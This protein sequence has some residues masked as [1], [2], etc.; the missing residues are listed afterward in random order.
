VTRIPVFSRADQ[1]RIGRVVKRVEQS[2]ENTVG[3]LGRDDTYEITKEIRFAKTTTNSTWPTY[4]IVTDRKFLVIFG[5]M[6]F[7]DKTLT[8]ETQTFVAYPKDPPANPYRIVY[9]PIGWLPKDTVCRIG[10]HN[11]LWH[12]IVDP[13]MEERKAKVLTTISA[14]GSGTVQ[15]YQNDAVVP[16]WTVT[17]HLNWMHSNRSMAAGVECLIR[18][19]PDEGVAGRWVFVERGC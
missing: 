15:V 18:W 2:R 10:L 3:E 4:P 19:F 13:W 12:I 16:G 9:S 11:Q 8:T 1:Q 7:D 5:D 17:A 14:G 6:D